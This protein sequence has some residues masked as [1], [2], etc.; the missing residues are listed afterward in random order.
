MERWQRGEAGQ[1]VRGGTEEISET[2]L[3][4]PTSSESARAT[5]LVLAVDITRAE[6]RLGILTFWCRS[7]VRLSPWTQ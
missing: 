7:V 2:H 1:G 5:H 6:E 3:A 4:G